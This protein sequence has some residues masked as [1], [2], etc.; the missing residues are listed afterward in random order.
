[1][2]FDDLCIEVKNEFPKFILVEKQDSWLMRVIGWLLLVLT[3]GSQREFMVSF[4]T[5][6]GYTVYTPSVW[7]HLSEQTRMEVLRHERIHMRQARKYTPFFFSL[8]YLLPILP[9]GLAYFR[10]KFEMEA[11]T[12]TMRAAR[13]FNGPKVLQNAAYKK[14]IVDHFITGQYGWMWPFKKTVEGWYDDAAKK[15]LENK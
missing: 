7:P 2:T 13:E 12:E 11:Y 15:I 5:T 3:F 1:M 14:V 10:A 9:L 4:I 6:L 8:L